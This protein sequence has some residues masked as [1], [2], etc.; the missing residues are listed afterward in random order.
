MLCLVQQRVSQDICICVVCDM[1]LQKPSMRDWSPKTQG[2][3]DKNSWIGQ[4]V[5]AGEDPKSH[6]DLTKSVMSM[7]TGRSY[8]SDEQ[9]LARETLG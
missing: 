1:F 6:W 5:M 7:V 2:Q 3:A 8:I 9:G 4:L